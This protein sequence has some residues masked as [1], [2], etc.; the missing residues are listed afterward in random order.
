MRLPSTAPPADLPASRNRAAHRAGN[1]RQIRTLGCIRKCY[2]KQTQLVE[3]C[4]SESDV[5]PIENK[6]LICR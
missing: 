6:E 3:I 5:A 1:S 4:P 2:T